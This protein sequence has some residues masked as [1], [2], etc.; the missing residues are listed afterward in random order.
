MKTEF[1]MPDEELS[2]LVAEVAAG[3]KEITKK[4][5]EK[6]QKLSKALPDEGTAEGSA[7]GPSASG[8]PS[9]SAEGASPS[10][11]GAPPAGDAPVAAPEGAPAGDAPPPGMDAGAPPPAG[12]GAPPPGGPEGAPADDGAGQGAPSVEELEQLYAQLPDEQLEAHYVAIQQAVAQRGQGQGGAEAPPEA[13]PAAPPAAPAGPS[14]SPSAPA[15][16]SEEFIALQTKVESLQKSLE[17]TVKALETATVGSP[18][19]KSITRVENGIVYIP[20]QGGE[21]AVTVGAPMKKSLKEMSKSEF[22]ARLNE[23]VKDP[24]LTKSDRALINDYFDGKVQI[25]SLEKFF[26]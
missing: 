17:T 25:T 1:T 15:F 7:G 18:M 4:E 23:V 16:K 19:R 21:Q 22:T 2:Q 26:Q 5:A 14:A 12:D 8:S 9:A 3:I 24:K 20:Y 6:V 11:E 13:P 10:A